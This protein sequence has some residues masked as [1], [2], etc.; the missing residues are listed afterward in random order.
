VFH[1]ST[2]FS[3]DGACYR[4]QEDYFVLHV[5]QAQVSLAGLDDIE[6]RT[7]TGY[8]WWS[9]QQKSATAELFYPPSCPTCCVSWRS[10][11]SG[12]DRHLSSD[13]LLQ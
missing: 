2:E 11:T 9:R 4:Q 13:V 8:R 10:L 12:T 6:R 3:F 7:V 5:G 1:R